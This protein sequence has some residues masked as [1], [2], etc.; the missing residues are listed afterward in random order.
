[1]GFL[2]RS[3]CLRVSCVGF[4]MGWDEAPVWYDS[5]KLPYGRVG[6]KTV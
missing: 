1:M 4:G 6:G 2:A 3:G 5:P